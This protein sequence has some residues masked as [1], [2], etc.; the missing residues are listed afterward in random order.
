MLWAGAV[1]ITAPSGLA[2]MAGTVETQPLQLV[3]ES[4]APSRLVLM[5][6]RRL[7]TSTCGSTSRRCSRRTPLAQ[8]EWRL[9]KEARGLR[10][11]VRGAKRTSTPSRWRWTSHASSIAPPVG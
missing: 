1:E 6:A 5:R 2:T 11:V 10:A 7:S 3:W 9:T 4:K 8:N